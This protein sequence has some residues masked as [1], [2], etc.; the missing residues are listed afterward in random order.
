M[1]ESVTFPQDDVYGKY[2]ILSLKNNGNKAAE[3]IKF[4]FDLNLGVINSVQFSKPGLINIESQDDSIRSGTIP[5]LNPKE[6]LQATVTIRN[7]QNDSK[8]SNTLICASRTHL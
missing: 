6:N 4:K 3:N 7:A 2:F 5:L 1:A 8:L